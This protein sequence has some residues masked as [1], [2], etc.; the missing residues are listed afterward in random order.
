MVSICFSLMISD[1]EDFF[2]CLFV[3]CMSCLEKYPFR[4]SAHFLKWIEVFF[5]G[6]V[7]GVGDRY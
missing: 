7:G 1:I 4:S 3:I 5:L 6:G 2:I